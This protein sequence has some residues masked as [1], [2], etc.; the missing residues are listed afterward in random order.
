MKYYQILETLLHQARIEGSLKQYMKQNEKAS[1]EKC[2]ALLEQLEA[3]L[4]T[5]LQNGSYARNGGYA[6]FQQDLQ[7][8]Q[9]KYKTHTDLG[10]KVTKYSL[11][12]FVVPDEFVVI[13]ISQDSKIPHLIL[14]LHLCKEI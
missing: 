11:K 7:E 9:R 5:K 14:C 2:Q 13:Q 8:I 4:M 10:V 12:R 3:S 6:D 1:I